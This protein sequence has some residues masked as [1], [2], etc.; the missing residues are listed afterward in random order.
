MKTGNPKISILMPS[1]NVGKYIEKSIQSVVMQTLDDIEIICIDAGSTDGTLEIIK[2]YTEQDQRIKIIHSDR[3]SY[4]YQMNLGL[5]TAQGKYIGIIETDDFTDNDMYETLYQIAEDNQADVVKSNFY[6]YNGETDSSSYF[7]NFIGLPTER[8]ISPKQGKRLLRKN[9]SIWTAIYNKEFL[10]KNDICFLETPGAS[11]Q[12]T[13]FYYKTIM[14]A[15]RIYLTS[16]AFVHYR[17]DNENSSMHSNVKVYAIC[18]EYDEI[19]R[20]IASH[21]KCRCFS[22]ALT[23]YRSIDYYWNYKRIDDEYKEEFLK[24]HGDKFRC[25]GNNKIQGLIDCVRDHGWK[26][27]IGYALRKKYN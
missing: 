18:D 17:V 20:Y 2:R 1:L 4:G 5:K 21:P 13:S 27:T 10:S 11:Y 22:R 6:I 19:F 12:D 15:E 3:K 14:C 16:R 8:T 25:N 9:K 23:H 24:K 7:D 26:Y